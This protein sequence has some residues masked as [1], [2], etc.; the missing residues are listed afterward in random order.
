[1]G[2]SNLD[3][4]ER[5]V[6]ALSFR[7]GWSAREIGEA[8][9]RR[10]A[11]VSNLIER[12][13][14]KLGNGEDV[15][16]ELPSDVLERRQMREWSKEFN[17]VLADADKFIGARMHGTAARLF[18]TAW[19]RSGHRKFQMVVKE[20]R[21]DITSEAARRGLTIDPSHYEAACE[22]AINAEEPLTYRVREG[23]DYRLLSGALKTADRSRSEDDSQLL[24]A[25]Q[26][27]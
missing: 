14:A 17:G 27:Q 15:P 2:R 1:V 25:T 19:H 23:R 26:C 8:L 22:A 16:P 6:L 11:S 5:V 18:I 12:I 24:Q 4:L 13:T 20:L 7:E 10:P 3:W 21:G 9:S